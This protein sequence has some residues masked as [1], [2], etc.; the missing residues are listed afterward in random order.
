MNIS[1]I[2]GHSPEQRIGAFDQIVAQRLAFGAGIEA[3]P[4]DGSLGLGVGV[5]L[6]HFQFGAQALDVSIGQGEQHLFPLV[7]LPG[8]EQIGPTLAHGF[9]V[10][11]ALL[12]LHVAFEVVKLAL[13]GWPQ[14]MAGHENRGDAPIFVGLDRLTPQQANGL[15]PIV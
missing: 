7:F 3:E 5:L 11:A 9:P 6:V 13:A 14:G 2:A 4:G 8:A 10:A 1:A 12:V 15:E